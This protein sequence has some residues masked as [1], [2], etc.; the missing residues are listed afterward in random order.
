MLNDHEQSSN[1][2]P[3]DGWWP[4]GFDLM[5]IQ[6]YVGFVLFCGLLRALGPLWLHRPL[7]LDRQEQLRHCIFAHAHRH[8][9]ADAPAP[10]RCRRTSASRSLDLAV[11]TA[12]VL[13]RQLR[14]R[15]ASVK[16]IAGKYSRYII[17]C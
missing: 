16:Q 14:H 9:R 2:A 5:L 13:D 7:A 12:F 8:R 6:K 15:L 10:S 11:Y 1:A 3:G 4:V 17:G